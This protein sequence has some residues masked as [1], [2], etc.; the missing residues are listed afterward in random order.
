MLYHMSFP[1]ADAL[2]VDTEWNIS[3]VYCMLWGG[4]TVSIGLTQKLEQIILRS[5]YF[6]QFTGNK[7]A[8][9]KKKKKK[10]KKKKA[11]SVYIYHIHMALI[12]NL[13]PV[14]DTIFLTIL[15]T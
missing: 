8:F 12:K 14:P 2:T 5:T 6:P 3:V 4:Y 9:P 1:T 7:S 10:K 13:F 11:N 15:H